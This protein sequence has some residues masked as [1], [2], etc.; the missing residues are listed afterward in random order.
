M[1]KG[2]E[3]TYLQKWYTDDQQALEKVFNVT[4]HL[5]NANQNHREVSPHTH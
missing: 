4:N 5:R 2:L 1:G 3:E